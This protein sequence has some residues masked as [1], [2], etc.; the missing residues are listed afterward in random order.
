MA[1]TNKQTK[2]ICFD[3]IVVEQLGDVASNFVS[4]DIKDSARGLE[5][6]LGFFFVCFFQKRNLLITIKGV[7]FF[8]SVVGG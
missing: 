2:G 4:E 3:R 5:L 8:S 1:K 6:E 7:F